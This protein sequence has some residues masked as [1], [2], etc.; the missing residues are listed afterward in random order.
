MERVPD[1]D[2]DLEE[3]AVAIEVGPMMPSART[4][5]VKEEASA[6]A[7]ASKLQTPKAAAAVPASPAQAT[8][9]PSTLGKMLL[10]NNLSYEVCSQC[11]CERHC[12]QEALKRMNAEQ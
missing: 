6:S 5:L 8:A 7:P 10:K 1:V 2:K 3:E 11:V 12:I 4:L 9:A